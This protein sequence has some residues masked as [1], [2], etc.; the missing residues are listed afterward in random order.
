MNQNKRTFKQRLAAAQTGQVIILMAFGMIALLAVLGLAIDGGRL[1]YL[2]RDAQNAADAAAMAAAYALCSG[3]NVVQAGETAAADNG[4]TSSEIQV[5]TPVDASL[6][7]AGD[8]VDDYVQVVI[9]SDIPSYFIHLVY[10]GDLG[11]SIDA[12]GN[13]DSGFDP[14][15]DGAAVMGTHGC[16]DNCDVVDFSGADVYLWGGIITNGDFK[17]TG[18]Y[19][20]INGTAEYGE[21]CTVNDPGTVYNNPAGDI[22]ERTEQLEIPIFYTTEEF[23]STG[24]IAAAA[25]ADGGRYYEVTGLVKLENYPDGGLFYADGDITISFNKVTSYPPITVVSTGTI[26][27]N[28]TGGASAVELTPYHEGLLFFS[29]DG[30]SGCKSNYGVD[31]VGSVT[32]WRGLIYAPYGHVQ[33]P[34][35]QLIAYGAIIADTVKTP[36]STTTIIYDHTV[37]PETEATF[38]L[39]R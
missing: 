26:K 15:T 37:I 6:I 30:S 21:S 31:F 16:T 19:H 28:V 23:E 32:R 38:S 18:A 9:S 24:A 5:T 14:L 35:S 34:G 12:L 8:D 20:E 25:L 3:G 39:S 10:G 17:S 36:S 1:F 11:V 4:F 22:V 7:P 13:C 29:E 33:V 2:E 27:A